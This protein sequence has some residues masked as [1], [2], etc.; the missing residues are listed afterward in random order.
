[1]KVR[2]NYL[3][4]KEIEQRMSLAVARMESV[5]D[6]RAVEE[7]IEQQDDFEQRLKEFEQQ[8]S[9]STGTEADQVAGDNQ[10]QAEQIQTPKTINESVTTI[11][12]S[13][14][15]PPLIT[16]KEVAA[17]EQ[18]RQQTKPTEDSW[19]ALRKRGGYTV[20]L[21]GVANKDSIPSFAAKYGLQGD[22][23]Y[24]TTEREGKAWHI[25]LYGMYDS[26]TEAT[27][28][29][30]DLPESLKSQQPWARKMPSLGTISGL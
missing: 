19:Q 21:I 15:P 1:M 30:Q 17:T 7:L 26:Y 6:P 18:Q 8:I 13:P 22:L 16:S 14:Q 29:L 2:E 12:Q 20:Q 24:I 4:K 9:T 25:L 27:K 11:Q 3:T 23:A 5:Y 28:A 10:E